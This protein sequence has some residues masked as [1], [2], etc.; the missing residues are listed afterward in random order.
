M[1]CKSFGSGGRCKKLIKEG[2]PDTSYAY[3]AFHRLKM[4]PSEYLSLNP[5]DKAAVIA[6]IDEKARKDR[7][8]AKQ[9]K[10]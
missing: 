6:F 10:K 4:L 3:Y 5:F 8:E 9:M 7:E 1:G 2:D